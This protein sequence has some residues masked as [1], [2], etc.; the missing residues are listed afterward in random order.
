MVLWCCLTV[1]CTAVLGKPFCSALCALMELVPS[2][3]LTCW[4]LLVDLAKVQ[5]VLWW[6]DGVC[7]IDGCPKHWYAVFVRIF[8]PIPVIFIY[9]LPSSFFPLPPPPFPS[10]WMC[11]AEAAIN[12]Q[13]L[14][15]K[16]VDSLLCLCQTWTFLTKRVGNSMVTFHVEKK[17]NG[18]EIKVNERESCGA[19][20]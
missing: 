15:D 11:K 2:Q 20:L 10:L 19:E 5:L 16:Y 13:S 17:K 3:H 9:F 18:C 8:L 12:V 1:I 4:Q 7:N 14:E 6:W